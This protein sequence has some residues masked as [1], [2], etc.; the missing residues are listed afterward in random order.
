MRQ[1]FGFYQIGWGHCQGHMRQGVLRIPLGAIN[2][3]GQAKPYV[4]CQWSKDARSCR[5]DSPR[6]L[7]KFVVFP[8]HVNFHKPPLLV[9]LTLEQFQS[10]AERTDFPG[11]QKFGTK[12][13]NSFL[14]QEECSNCCS[15]KQTPSNLKSQSEI[16]LVELEFGSI[17]GH[18]CCI[19][20]RVSLRDPREVFGSGVCR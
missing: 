20:L 13:V 18:V 12:L 17:V 7:H 5:S 19:D 6:N 11:G 1:A 10:C 4:L 15:L 14:S 2:H 8:C 3:W 9:K 16:Q